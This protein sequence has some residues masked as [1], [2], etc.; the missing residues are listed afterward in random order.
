[1]TL[2]ELQKK[3]ADL[4]AR[5]EKIKNEQNEQAQIKRAEEDLKGAEA[6]LEALANHNA[7]ELRKIET[8]VSTV[9]LKKPPSLLYRRFLDSSEKQKN[10][11][12][13]YDLVRKSCVYPSAD[14]LDEVLDTYPQAVIEFA[15]VVVELAQV[16]KESVEKK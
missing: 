1:M 15:G 12:A 5:A 10:T 16:R 2:E 4:L 8:D 3:K 13:F 9:I 11:Q 6:Y 7:S 14:V